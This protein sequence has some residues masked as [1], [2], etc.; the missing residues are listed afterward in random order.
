LLLQRLFKTPG[1]YS[2]SELEG[3]ARHCTERARAARKVERLMRKIAA[4]VLL[5]GRIGEL[6]EGLI[7][8]VK[9]KGTFVRLTHFPAEGKVVRGEAGL[10]VGDKVQVR[11]LSV[12]LERGFI[13]FEAGQS[14]HKPV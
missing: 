12:D 4:A 7:T 9:P 3:L 5:R 2:A 11:L 10:D 13:D 14:S 1:I 6:F 8:G